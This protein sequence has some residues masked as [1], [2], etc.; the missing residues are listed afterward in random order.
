ML[1][2][3]FWATSKRDRL[4]KETEHRNDAAGNMQKSRENARTCTG[5]RLY[6]GQHP[7]NITR[8]TRKA[9]ANQPATALLIRGLDCAEKLMGEEGK[10]PK[11]ALKA[12]LAYIEL[13]G[14]N[15]AIRKCIKPFRE[16]LN[17]M[18][19]AAADRREFSKPRLERV[20]RNMRT[21]IVDLQERREA[22]MES[23]KHRGIY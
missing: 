7:Y 21:E 22:A 19:A 3:V 10:G 4:P 17:E 11:S 15:R 23:L 2:K 6:A 13:I 12:L 8:T 16:A 9:F 1:R 5:V 18:S 14:E 20:L